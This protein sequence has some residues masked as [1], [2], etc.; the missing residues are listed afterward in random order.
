MSITEAQL[1]KLKDIPVLKKLKKLY[2]ENPQVQGSGRRR[3]M[4][5][6]NFWDDVGNW[7]K[8]A[9]VDVDDWAKKV[10]P[11]TALSKAAGLIGMI[12]GLNEVALL[13]P[14]ISGVAGLTGYGKRGGAK[15]MPHMNVVSGQR[16]GMA[17]RDMVGMGTMTQNYQSEVK[18]M[19]GGATFPSHLQPFLTS[20]RI[21][22]NGV[23]QAVGSIGNFGR[24]KV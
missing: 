19:I 3:K 2:D 24:I 9:A 15:R 6:G 11:L 8:Q 21:K 14:A 5:G 18:R 10:K 4:K 7:F 17:P 23:S 22:G 20:K 16:G 12:P 13:S 1:K